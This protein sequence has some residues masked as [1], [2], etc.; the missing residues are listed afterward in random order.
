MQQEHA[1]RGEL[2]QGDARAR[3]RRRFGN[4]TF[5]KEETRQVSGLG[6]FDTATQDLR[7]AA[8]LDSR[9][10]RRAVAANGSLTRM[11]QH[12]R[13]RILFHL[14]WTAALRVAIALPLLFVASFSAFGQSIQPGHLPTRKQVAPMTAAEEK[15]LAFVL[16]WWR[17]VIEAR[18]TELGA[19]Y[20]AEDFIQHNPNI[21]TGRAPLMTLF[22][23]LGPPI[24]PIPERLQNPPVVAGAKGNFV[25]LVF[26]HKFKIPKTL[27]SRSMNTASICF[28]FNAERYRSTG[29]LLGRSPAHRRSFRPRLRRPPRGTQRKL[30]RQNNRS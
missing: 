28:A 23:S 3:A 25:W 7:F 11:K 13:H 15:N 9:A 17:K 27:H 29:M 16:D 10:P 22:K 19:D 18:H 14:A 4:P 24:E 30:Q 5:H 26:E 20:A 6:F 21:P 1:A 2:T 12:I 8:E